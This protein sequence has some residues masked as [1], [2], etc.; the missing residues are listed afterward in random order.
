MAH[1]F[2]DQFLPYLAQMEAEIDESFHF[3]R[4]IEARDITHDVTVNLASMPPLVV[5]EP[6][7]FIRACFRNKARDYYRKNE[8]YEMRHRLHEEGSDVSRARSPLEEAVS[9]EACRKIRELL[10]PEQC[11]IVELRLEGHKD[12]EISVQLNISESAVRMRIQYARKRV[13]AA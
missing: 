1:T 5:E 6:K 8:R 4:G 13:L 9:R 7:K 12:S 3:S 11:E 10:T 2:L